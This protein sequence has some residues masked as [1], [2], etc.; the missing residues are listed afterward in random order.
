MVFLVVRVLVELQDLQVRVVAQVH[1]DLV[2]LQ[3]LQDQ[4][5]HLVQ[6]DLQVRVVLQELQELQ[7]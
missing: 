4:V 1:Q 6:A 7:V 3:D 2:G 5:G